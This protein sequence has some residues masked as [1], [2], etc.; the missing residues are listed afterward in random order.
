MSPPSVVCHKMCPYC[1]GEYS[2][3]AGP[4]LLGASG[5][6]STFLPNAID[7]ERITISQLQRHRHNGH[8]KIL[9]QGGRAEKQQES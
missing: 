6:S 2:C 5:I 8:P 3:Y 7:G 9:M 1:S 4:C